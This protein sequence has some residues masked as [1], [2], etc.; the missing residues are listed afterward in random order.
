MRFRL[1]SRH[2]LVLAIDIL[3]LLTAVLLA[4]SIRQLE[5]ADPERWVALLQR[6]TGATYLTILVHLVTFYTFELYNLGIDFRRASGVARVVAAVAAAMA[7]LA[8]LYYVVPFWQMSRSM[9]LLHAGV[10]TALVTGWR[11]L[12]SWLWR[13]VDPKERALVIGAGR[14]GAMVVEAIR[15]RPES[16]LNPI[17]FLDDD[18][19]KATT[20]HAGLPVL[21][22]STRLRAVIEE[23]RIATLI[24]A[25]KE[26]RESALAAELLDLKTRGVRV[27]HAATLYKDLLGRVPVLYVDDFYFLFG[28]DLDRVRSR[29]LR[30][31]HRLFDI[32]LSSL[33]LLLGGP[34]L[35]LGML[36]V[37]LSS[38]GPVFYRQERVGLNKVP[39]EILKLRTMRLD[40]EKGTGAVMSRPGHDPRVTPVGRW[41]RRSRID[42]LPQLINVLRGDMSII[43]PRP[44]RPEFTARFEQEIP[45]YGLRFAVKPGL[46]GWAQVNF[47]YGSDAE[48][49]AVKLQ[50][51]LYY[52]QE[53]S[54]LLDL[55]I[56][57][58]TVQTVLLKAG[59]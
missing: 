30:N 50:Y 54:L 37:K 20:E 14:M 16:N 56:V 1:S 40:A 59:S 23:H 53:M 47:R 11:V 46:T 13:R 28:P 52:I 26:R 45:Y 39:F 9:I 25:F 7:L 22:D 2:L 51:D 33:G 5:L 57:L 42:E 24:L 43:G 41:L 38:R 44:E 49:T 17:G 27:V 32:G 18:P 29:F 8:A 55:H 15:S 6:R 35:G 48:D 19:A 21:G 4:W 34:L 36:A 10:T 12:V 58:K 31:L 3:L